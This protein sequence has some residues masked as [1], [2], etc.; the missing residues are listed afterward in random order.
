MKPS[1]N[2]K[3]PQELEDYRRVKDFGYK[4]TTLVKVLVNMFVNG[5]LYL[6]ASEIDAL[7]QAVRLET[8][9]NAT[10]TIL[11]YRHNSKL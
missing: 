4:Y 5:R 2:L 9:K 3:S 7:Y 8:K 11:K 1:I 10:E 6:H